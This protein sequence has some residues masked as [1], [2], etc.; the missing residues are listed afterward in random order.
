LFPNSNWVYYILYNTALL[1]PI[2]GLLTYYIE[3]LPLYYTRSRPFTH[4][5]S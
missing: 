4:G 2:A 3:M 1:F 5:E